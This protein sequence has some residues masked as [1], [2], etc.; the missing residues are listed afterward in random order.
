MKIFLDKHLF[1]LVEG[2]QKLKQKVRQQF[3]FSKNAP[4]TL[5]SF[6]FFFFVN[7]ADF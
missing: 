1:L 6:F 3:K 5:T 7:L 4:R 2:T